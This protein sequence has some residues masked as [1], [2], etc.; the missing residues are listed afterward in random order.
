MNLLCKETRAVVSQ[1]MCQEVPGKI[2]EPESDILP[3]STPKRH[4]I[5]LNV[6]KGLLDEAKLILIFGKLN[7]KSTQLQKKKYN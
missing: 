6:K 4:R 1:L 7:C 5:E 2:P 3:Y